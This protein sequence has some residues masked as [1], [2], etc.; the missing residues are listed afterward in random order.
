MSDRGAASTAKVWTQVGAAAEYLSELERPGF[1]VWDALDEAIR[2]WIF[3][4]LSLDGEVDLGTEL[5][6]DDPDPLR[7]TLA[8]LLETTA[9]SGAVDGHELS[10][11]LDSALRK[12]LVR[13]ADRVND[14]QQF[15]RFAAFD[16]C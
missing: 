8:S 9:S 7:T 5:L 13:T 2:W 4:R 6:W 12:W 16:V 14:G 3:D 15:G 1:T 10:T 11:V